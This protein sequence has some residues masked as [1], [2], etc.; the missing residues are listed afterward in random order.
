M[1]LVFTHVCLDTVLFW[2]KKANEGKYNDVL[3]LFEVFV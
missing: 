3:L 2:I 1:W